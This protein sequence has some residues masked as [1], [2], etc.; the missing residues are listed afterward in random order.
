VTYAV[1]TASGHEKLE[2]ASCSHVAAVRALF[3]ERLDD[4]ELRTLGELLGRLPGG[5]ADSAECAVEPAQTV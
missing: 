2:Q 1:L 3:E 5:G 4:D